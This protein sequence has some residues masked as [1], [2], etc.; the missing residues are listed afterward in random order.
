MWLSAAVVGLRGFPCH[1]AM[2]QA[3]PASPFLGDAAIEG[4]EHARMG[5]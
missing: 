1:L 5:W 4:T 3:M 2:G